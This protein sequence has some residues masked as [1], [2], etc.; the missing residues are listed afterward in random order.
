MGGRVVFLR[1]GTET[2]PPPEILAPAG[3][4][5]TRDG[6]QGVFL[7]EGDVARFVPVDAGERRAAVTPIRSGLAGGELAVLDPP[8]TLTS[9]MVVRQE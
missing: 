2:L 8:S 3:A 4:V 9:G 7:V 6:K 1:S 5:V